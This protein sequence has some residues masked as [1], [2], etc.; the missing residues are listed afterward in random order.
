M[1]CLLLLAAWLLLSATGFAQQEDGTATNQTLC[2]LQDAERIDHLNRLSDYY[3]KTEKKDSAAYYARMAYEK[4][5]NGNYIHG[6]AVSLSHQSQIAK[7]F[8]DDFPKAE[9]LAKAALRWFEKTTDKSGL[10]TLYDHLIYAV[11]AQ[12]RF[13]EALHYARKRY[14]VTKGK[15]NQAGMFDALGWM[16]AI[17]RQSGDYEKALMYAQQ[18]HD[19]ALKAKKKI[20]ISRILYGMAQLYMLIE[21]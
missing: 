4:A 18:T 13:D 2:S 17:Y 8:D 7:H 5:E 14:D 9:Q 1:P 20:W 10:D 12:S 3:I 19:L 15:G 21:D 16:F 11:F 6:I